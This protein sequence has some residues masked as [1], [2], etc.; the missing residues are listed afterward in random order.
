MVCVPRHVGAPTEVRRLETGWAAGG[1]VR[2]RAMAAHP[3]E[4]VINTLLLRRRSR[5][6][7]RT[8]A[9]AT[10]MAASSAIASPSRQRLTADDAL[11]VT[12]TLHAAMHALDRGDGDLFASLFTDGGTC[13][14]KMAGAVVTGSDKLASFYVSLHEKF[15]TH[16]HTESNVVLWPVEGDDKGEADAGAGD[17]GDVG[18]ADDREGPRRCRNLSYWRSTSIINGA[19]GAT[20]LHDDLLEQC[21]DGRWRFVHRIIWHTW[22][23]GGGR[24]D[25]ASVAPSKIP[26]A[27]LP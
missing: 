26:A 7:P 11:S 12:N 2:F 15:A 23:E 18:G 16:I 22:T 9:S 14:V 3:A 6:D 21:A 1:K 8:S 27:S 10:T 20:G 13:E 5:T 24:V 17:G 25:P 4:E 19:L